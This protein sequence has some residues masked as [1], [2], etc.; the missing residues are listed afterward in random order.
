[1]HIEVQRADLVRVLTAVGKIVETR[2]TYPILANVLLT[3]ASGLLTVRGTDLD[4][5]ITTSCPATGA[6]GAACVSAHDLL[7]IVRKLGGATVDLSLAATDGTAGILTVKS[8]RSRF[9]VPSM[10]SESFPTLKTD[11]Y[12]HSFSADLS[13]LFAPVAFAISKHDPARHYLEGIYVH[14]HNGHLRAVGTDAHRMA[15]YDVALPDGAIGMPSIIVPPK[16]ADLAASFKSA[17][18]ISV[19]ENRIRFALGD[20]V[21]CAKL[22]GGNYVNYERVIPLEN[23]RLLRADKADFAAAAARVGLVASESS[24]RAVR[25]GLAPGSITLTADDRDGRDAVDEVAA[26]LIG[27]PTFV[28]YNCR[29]LEEM[30]AAV[31]GAVVEFDVIDNTK[32]TRVRSASDPAFVGLLT[33]Y[34]VAA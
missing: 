34:M 4:I 2:N 21:V 28:A 27:A 17:I 32:N 30:L 25:L 9:K 3:A 16:V 5:E 23:D 1:M 26:E 22:I 33:P 31:P 19:C 15:I 11:G 12:T 18:D 20:T 8:G 7:G 6:D 29:Y 24:G 13:V 10:S 14:E